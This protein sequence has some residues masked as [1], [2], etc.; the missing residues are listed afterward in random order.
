MSKL[1]NF[2]NAVDLMPISTL[3]AYEGPQNATHA[4]GD[5]SDNYN[6]ISTR[7]VLSSLDQNAFGVAEYRVTHSKKPEYNG[8]EKHMIKIQLKDAR[9]GQDMPQI[10][11]INS[12]NRSSGFRIM[13]GIFRL[14][15]SNGLVVGTTHN[16]FSV[17][18]VGGNS[19][20]VIDAVYRV[21]DQTKL[22]ASEIENWKSKT[23][24][25]EAALEFS[26]QALELRFGEKAPMTPGNALHVRRI[27]DNG[28]SLWQIFNRVQENLSSG[29]RFR[30]N[31]V[32]KNSGRL[33]RTARK[34][35]QPIKAIDTDITFNRKLW[36]IAQ[37]FA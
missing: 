27:E 35:I 5:V 9:I 3:L 16:A 37:K 19:D 24:T 17:R 6:F 18:H 23:L 15:C 31:I 29:M 34:T 14:V 21:I 22:V 4:A 2:K 28:A 1:I 36:D 20:K 33:L 30:T 25:E 7:K 8:F 12:H 26:K 11:L 13:A 10:V 32:D